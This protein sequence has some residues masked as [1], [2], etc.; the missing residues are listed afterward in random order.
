MKD[1]SLEWKRNIDELDMLY[2]SEEIVNIWLRIE[3][4]VQEIDK[5]VVHYIDQK[6]RNE[7]AALIRLVNL[8]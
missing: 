1:D 2:L 5:E 4:H 6:R 8:I 7:H 3:L